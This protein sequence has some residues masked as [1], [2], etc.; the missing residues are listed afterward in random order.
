MAEEILVLRGV[1]KS[2]GSITVLADVDLSV[3]SGSFV[4]LLGPS[5]CGKTT[6]LRI[7]AG[8]LLPDSGD[9]RLGGRE[10]TYLPPQARDLA[11]VFQDYALFPHMSVFDNVAFGIRMRG[12]AE[13]KRAIP[14]RVHEV[15]EL[16]RLGGYGKR[17]PSQLSGGQQQRVAIARAL[18]PKPTLLLMDEP[19]SNLDA[20][21]R[22]EMRSELKQIQRKAA[23]T[24]VYVTH[25]QEEALTLS[26]VIVVMGH[27][28]VAQVG[29]PTE[30][31]DAPGDRFVADFIGKANLLGGA[32]S[33]DRTTFAVAPGLSLL[34]HPRCPFDTTSLSIRPEQ[35]VV[36]AK[37][38]NDPNTF[39]GT[40]AE[41][42]YAGATT[43][44]ACDLS[45]VAVTALQVN[46]AGA[47]TWAPGQAVHVSLPPEALRPLREHAW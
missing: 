33:A 37:P 3:K 20:K 7:I 30:I 9:V 38:R 12:T 23:V 24:T 4:S 42:T 43:T 18:A 46:R 45:G 16:V 40:V 28:R 1:D 8:I 41:V 32:L 47:D 6:L 17:L 26:D 27:G 2:Y 34:I 36:S 13:Q 19:L 5:G 14:D 10:V 21:V 39:G 25:D 31:Y 44:I 29:S 15:L 22:E 35:V 11:M